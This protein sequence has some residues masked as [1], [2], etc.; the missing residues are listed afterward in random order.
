MEAMSS[1]RATI[2][3]ARAGVGDAIPVSGAEEEGASVSPVVVVCV[4]GA[5]HVRRE[6]SAMRVVLEALEAASSAMAE[7]DTESALD[8]QKASWMASTTVSTMYSM[9][10]SSGRDVVVDIG[11]QELGAEAVDR[12]KSDTMKVEKTQRDA[13]IR[14][15]YKNI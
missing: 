9:A 7:G 15:N 12:G 2:S 14:E 10:A 4:A 11:C 3:G 1:A 13:L 5:R 8:G 6:E